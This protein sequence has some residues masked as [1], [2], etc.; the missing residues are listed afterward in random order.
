MG[1]DIHMYIEYKSKKREDNSWFNFGGRI[2]PGRNYFMFGILAGV[3]CIV[4][5]AFEKKGLPENLSFESK[6]GNYVYIYEDDK[7]ENSCTLETAKSWEKSWGCKIIY[8]KD[9]VPYKVENP[10]W[11]THSWLSVDEFE[12]AMEIYKSKAEYSIYVKY[13]A[14]LAAMKKLAEFD[15]EVRIVF[16]FDN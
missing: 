1:C 4:E 16:W 10:D 7:S 2:N 11:H 9:N 12:K 8:T 14:I 15:N 5:G 6:N 3:R 13:E